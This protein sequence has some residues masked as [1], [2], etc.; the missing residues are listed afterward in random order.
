MLLVKKYKTFKHKTIFVGLIV[1]AVFIPK[2]ALLGLRW[3]EA[4]G[5]ISR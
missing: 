5:T 4:S 2:M 1:I 3:A